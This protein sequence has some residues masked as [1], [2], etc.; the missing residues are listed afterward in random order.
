MGGIIGVYSHG[1]CVK[2]LFYGTDYHSHMGTIRGGMAVLDDNGIKRFIK[3]ITTGPFR[4]KFQDDLPKL[5]G[6]RGIGV[7]S[8]TD[9]QPLIIRSHLGTY[10]IVTVGKIN[11]LDELV[12]NAFHKGT[13]HFSEM[14]GGVIN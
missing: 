11:N 12:E 2:D 5:H 10:A 8:D 7:I 14:S 9:D 3:D 13:S 6:N 1:D 4:S